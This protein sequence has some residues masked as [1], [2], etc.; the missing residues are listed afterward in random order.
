MFGALTWLHFVGS[1]PLSRVGDESGCFS[2]MPFALQ[3]F[4]RMCPS[5]CTL[6]KNHHS[7]NFGDRLAPFLL[8][9]LP[10]YGRGRH[11]RPRL[12]PIE[13]R[14]ISVWPVFALAIKVASS[15]AITS[16]LGSLRVHIWHH[17][18]CSMT[19]RCCARAVNP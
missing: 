18:S 15:F 7:R 17:V 12:L 3:G 9:A 1:A 6:C 5:A 2:A 16:S 4:P 19:F 10:W 13:S 8:A 11:D 14:E